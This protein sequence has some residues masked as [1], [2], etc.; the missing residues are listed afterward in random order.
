MLTAWIQFPQD[1]ALES[2]EL[3]EYFAGKGR[4]AKMAMRRGYPSRALDVQYTQPK[5]P[6]I[7]SFRKPRGSMDF[8]GDAGY[9]FLS[10][11]KTF[12]VC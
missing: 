9:V 3:I 5:Q 4:I 1:V 6:C 10:C 7:D 8:N 11:V 12:V 2:L